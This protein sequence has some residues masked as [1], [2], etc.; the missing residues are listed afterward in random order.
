[1]L[2]SLTYLILRLISLK[3]YIIPRRINIKFGRAFGSLMYYVFPLRKSVAITNLN[4]A[5]KE[6]NHGEKKSL[7]LKV[8]QHYG[9]LAFEFLQMYYKKI[10]F[11]NFILD[12][13]TKRIL[14]TKSGIIL[15]TAHIGNWEMITSIISKYKKV[16]GIVRKQKNSGGNKFFSECR[17]IKNVSLVANKGSK[18]KMLNALNNGEI[19]LL[20]TD[21]NAKKNGT[22]IDFF[23]EQASIPKGAG[24]FYYSTK[25]TLVIGFCILN[26]NLQ[27]EFKLRKI[28]INK[29]IE[30]KENTIVE[31][32]SIYSKLLQDEIIKYPEQYFWFHKKWNKNIY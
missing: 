14:S 28:K 18:R 17:T 21:Q 20:A 8:Y 16:T 2:D 25:S 19:L 31:V 27:Y 30:Q 1:L 4:I 6:K 7:L 29:N 15:M 12:D 24:H 10:K 3:L 26:E 23:G 32:N 22:Y 11:D 5:F 13:E 9:I